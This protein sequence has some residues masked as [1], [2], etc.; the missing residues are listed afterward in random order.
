[1]NN[2]RPSV[3][4]SVYIR[5]HT[6]LFPPAPTHL[7]VQHLYVYVRGC[8]CVCVCVC[9]RAARR[10]VGK[11]RTRRRTLDVFA[12]RQFCPQTCLIAFEP[13][14]LPTPP[15]PP[16]IHHRKSYW[17]FCKRVCTSVLHCRP[18]RTLR[19]YDCVYFWLILMVFGFEFYLADKSSHV[20]PFH[21]LPP[22][23]T[24]ITENDDTPFSSYTNTP[25]RYFTR[26]YIYIYECMYNRR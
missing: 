17:G 18:P 7:S 11:E 14:P 20:H 3:S 8:G 10:H 25:Y 4:S 24:H 22:H 6:H 19:H 9:V 1:M 16:P 13:A 12:V 23:H 21:T 26:T 2:C 5:V 15:P